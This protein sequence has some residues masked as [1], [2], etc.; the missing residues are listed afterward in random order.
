MNICAIRG[1]ECEIITFL[2]VPIGNISR[3]SLSMA[4]KTVEDSAV[5]E[6]SYEF[7]NSNLAIG[8]AADKY[9]KQ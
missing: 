5:S 9:V 4:L 2:G 7:W 1:V 8:G 3:L 6:I